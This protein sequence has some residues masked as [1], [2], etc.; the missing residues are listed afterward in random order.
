MIETAALR[1]R[2]AQPGGRLPP[3]G[4]TP[5]SKDGGDGKPRLFHPP[6]ARRAWGGGPR[7]AVEGPRGI[8]ESRAAP[9]F[10]R[11]D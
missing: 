4:R 6:Y 5:P 2:S 9:T 10:V 3:F 1:V 8:A 7:T 11:A